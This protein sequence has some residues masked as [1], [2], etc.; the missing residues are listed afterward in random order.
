[1]RLSFPNHSRSFDA[2]RSRVRFWGYDSALEISFFVEE[3]ALKMLDPGMGAS[4]AEF[5]RSF[6]DARKQIHEVAEKVYLQ[7]HKRVL[8]HSLAAADF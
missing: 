5:L 2:R 3:D 7:G 8:S 1:M 4:E 6:D